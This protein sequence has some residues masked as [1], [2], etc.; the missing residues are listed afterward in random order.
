MLRAGVRTEDSLINI[1]IRI[2]IFLI[3]KTQFG[4]W[5][6]RSIFELQCV[7]RYIYSMLTWKSKSVNFLCV[8]WNP[9]LHRQVLNKIYDVTTCSKVIPR[10]TFISSER[11]VETWALW[12][13]F[14]ENVFTIWRRSHLAYTKTKQ[15]SAGKLWSDIHAW[16]YFDTYHP[17]EQ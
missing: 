14:T 8:Y 16:R 1:L 9:D 4:S 12:N 6:Y 13:T 11:E 3:S 10:A 15:W 2:E 17:P 7:E 5:S